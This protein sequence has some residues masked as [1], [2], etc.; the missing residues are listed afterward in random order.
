MIRSLVFLGTLA[1]KKAKKKTVKKIGK[2]K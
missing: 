1:K 2:K